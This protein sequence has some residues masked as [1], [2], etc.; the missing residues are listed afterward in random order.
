MKNF[1][2]KLMNED[3]DGEGYQIVKELLGDYIRFLEDTEYTQIK[4]KL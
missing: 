4:D 3:D 1:E 2:L